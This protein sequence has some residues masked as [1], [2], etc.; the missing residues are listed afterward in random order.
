MVIPDFLCFLFFAAVVVGFFFLKLN[1]S[2]KLD[3]QTNVMVKSR[4]FHVA[5]IVKVK[6]YLPVKGVEKV[7]HDF[8]TSHL[9]N[10]NAVNDGLDQR[11]LI[12]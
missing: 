3:K 12:F 9:D 1:R 11:S 4:I 8:N 2:L 5:V 7:V 6:S 10:C